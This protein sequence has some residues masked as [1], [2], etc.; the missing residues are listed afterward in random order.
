MKPLARPVAKMKLEALAKGA[1]IVR[2]ELGVRAP[3]AVG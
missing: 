2:Q 1:Q 3:A